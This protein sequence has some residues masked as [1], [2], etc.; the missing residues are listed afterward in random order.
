MAEGLMKLVHGQPKYDGQFMMIGNRLRKPV[1]CPTELYDRK[2]LCTE[3]DNKLGKYD[4][5]A[6]VL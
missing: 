3:C 6:I 4:L 5:A 1:S 2:I